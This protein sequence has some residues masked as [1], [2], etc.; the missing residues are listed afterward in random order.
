V[1]KPDKDFDVLRYEGLEAELLKVPARNPVLPPGSGRAIVM[2]IHMNG[3]NEPESRITLRTPRTQDLHQG[4][5]LQLI[6]VISW[7]ER[8]ETFIIGSGG[9]FHF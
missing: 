1:T 2:D 4:L 7:H 9:N 3:G 6:F 8:S 5:L